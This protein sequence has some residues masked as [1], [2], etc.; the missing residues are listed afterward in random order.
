MGWHGA[1]AA[2]V[3]ANKFGAIRYQSVGLMGQSYAIPTKRFD[4]RIRRLV[5]LELKQ[6]HLNIL[7]FCSFTRAHPEMKFF[8]TSVGCGL[9]GY[10]YDQ[11]A[12]H[13]KSAINCSFPEDW[14][15]YLEDLE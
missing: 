3:A 14:D 2:L 13:F 7:L 15:V 6:I 4:E 5:S 12:P 10:V 8:V 9:A 11:I 1:G